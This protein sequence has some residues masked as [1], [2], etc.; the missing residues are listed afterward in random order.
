[1]SE[2]GQQDGSMGVDPTEVEQPVG[3]DERIEAERLRSELDDV[4]SALERL[5]AGTYGTCRICGEGLDDA[6]LELRP[7]AGLCATHSG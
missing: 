2:T 1:M 3:V 7:Q 5:D 6:E 4:E